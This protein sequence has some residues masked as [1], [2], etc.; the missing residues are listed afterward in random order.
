MIFEL[1]ERVNPAGV[2]KKN[3]GVASPGTIYRKKG[4]NILSRFFPPYSS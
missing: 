3:P 2:S 1:L 4:I